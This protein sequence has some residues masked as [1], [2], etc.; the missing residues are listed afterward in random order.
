MDTVIGPLRAAD[1]ATADWIFRQAFGQHF[2]LPDPQTF[3]GDAAL[4]ATRWRANPDA[5]FGAYEG[6]RLVGSSFATTWGSFGF[7]GPVSVHPDLWNKGVAQQLLEHTVAHLDRTARQSALFTFPNSPK[8]IALYQKFG[9]WPQYLTP[10][11]TKQPVQNAGDAGALSRYS[12]LSAAERATC[13]A[14]CAALTDKIYSG[15]NL[16][17]EIRS[18]AEQGL[19]DTLLIHDARGVAGF[20]C[21]HIG[22]GSEAVTGRTF[23]K[24]AAVRPGSDAPDLFERLLDRCEAVAAESGCDTIMAINAARHQAYRQMIARGFRTLLSGV[25][26]LRPHEPAHNRPDCF[27]IDDLR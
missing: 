26:M 19:G 7:V 13:L 2:G 21:C 8:H 24:F 20:A 4:I 5:A 18:I 11:M 23:I 10:V 14:Q 15:L 3:A 6:D 17:S 16:Q 12:S 1:L 27:V 22:A 25:A 9:F